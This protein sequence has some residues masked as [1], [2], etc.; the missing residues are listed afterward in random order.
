MNTR[1][2]TAADTCPDVIPSH[3]LLSPVRHT[4][5]AL[6]SSR[7]PTLVAPQLKPRMQTADGALAPDLAATLDSMFD[8]LSADGQM[9]SAEEQ[10]RWLLTINRQ[11]GRGSEYRAATKA[12]EA[13]G[14]D[15]IR[16]DFTNVYV[17]EAQVR[18]YACIFSECAA[19]N[20]TQW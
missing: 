10:E 4:E 7:P 14:G 17:A 9:L 15:L 19:F 13:R 3:G 6:G 11:L 20:S 5:L 2:K 18:V 1:L 8:R 16:E 12:R